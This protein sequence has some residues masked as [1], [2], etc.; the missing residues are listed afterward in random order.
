MIAYND[1]TDGSEEIILEFCAKYP[2]FIPAKYPHKVQIQNPQSE[3]NKLFAY[4]NFALSFIPKNEWLILIDTDHIYDAKK[5]YKSFYLAKS[6]YERV[7]YD[8][9]N[10]LVKNGKVSVEKSTYMKDGVGFVDKFM[11]HYLDHWLLCNFGFEFIPQY[12]NKEKTIQIEIWNFK[13][14][15]ID[16]FTEISNYHFP[17]IKERRQSMNDKVEKFT[18]NEIKQSRLVGTRIDSA[19]LDEKKILQIYDSFDWHRANY[20]KP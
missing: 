2:S 3:E 20:K 16:K 13:P 19:L 15:R 7:M 17:Y 11:L 14:M 10:F 8:R 5:L 18:L 12:I 9:I 1:C 4:C 6:P